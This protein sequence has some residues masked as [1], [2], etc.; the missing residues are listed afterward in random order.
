MRKSFAT[1][2]FTHS[3]FFTILYLLTETVIVCLSEACEGQKAAL[4]RAVPGR[5]RREV[6]VNRSQNR[7]DLSLSTALLRSR[8]MR[9]AALPGM[10]M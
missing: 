7:A 6:P 2:S 9:P 4:R 3:L 1:H 5:P 10:M 8:P